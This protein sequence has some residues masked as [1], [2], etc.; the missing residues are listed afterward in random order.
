MCWETH[1][2]FG[3]NQTFFSLL[4]PNRIKYLLYISPERRCILLTD[5][6]F[7]YEHFQD[8]KHKQRMG[9]W[10][11]ARRCC[12]TRV[13]PCCCKAWLVLWLLAMTSLPEM[14]GARVV[15]LCKTASPLHLLLTER[16]AL[17]A[18]RQGQM[19][20]QLVTASA[21]AE[22]LNIYINWGISYLSRGTSRK[23][24]KG[25]KKKKKDNNVFNDCSSFK[26][27]L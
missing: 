25:G 7:F 9:R 16:D 27:N 6:D 5:S 12:S 11:D 4:F 17:C 22:A 20:P 19:M 23:V 10:G 26:G 21:G 2:A 8:L 3:K 14:R 1:K 13:S 18:T 24:V 15:H